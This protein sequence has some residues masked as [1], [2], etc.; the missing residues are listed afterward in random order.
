MRLVLRITI[1]CLLISIF[2]CATVPY[3]DTTLSQPRPGIYHRV[4]KGQTLWR[5]AKLYNVDM[6]ELVRINNIPNAF[7]IKAGQIIFIP[8]SAE[9]QS[10][11]KEKI[12]SSNLVEDFI[13]PI[14]GEVLSSFGQFS[15]DVV[16]KGIDIKA[17]YRSDVV[18]SRSGRVIFLSEGLKHFGKTIII[19]HD[20]DFS[21]VYAR[22]SEILVKL[23]D[24]VRQGQLIARVGI[25]GPSNIAYL[26]F[27]IRKKH[28]PQNPYYYLP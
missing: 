14:K 20:E 27:E 4:E 9:F 19:Q 6:D 18:A 23:G 3:Q 1:F 21:T 25:S 7:Q 26:H 22:N 16:N 24:S 12:S 17:D 2:G 28:I 13:W 11:P 15:H 5:I 10:L 8:K